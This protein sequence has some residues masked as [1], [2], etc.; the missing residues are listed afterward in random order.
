MQKKK[1]IAGIIILFSF[2]F[3]A[4]NLFA[5]WTQQTSGTSQILYS[6]YFQDSNNG[7]AVGNNSTI[8]NTT[9][10][11]TTWGSQT[12]PVA[13][14]LLW[15][16]RFADTSNGWAVGADGTIINTT[17]GGTTWT[18]QTSGT[19][20]TLWA[21]SVVD[22]N[23]AWAVG[24][25]GTILTTSD[26]GTTWTSQTSGTSNDL[27]G[28]FF[29]NSTTGW[30]V[31]VTGTILYTS[32]GG[33]SWT[34]QT[35]NTTQTLLDVF[36]FDANTGWAVG[37]TY[38]NTVL[39]GT[40]D[41]GTTWT[42]QT[43]DDM[44]SG[45]NSV[46]FLSADVGW[47]VGDSGELFHTSDG[48]TTWI[49]QD[50]GSSWDLYGVN[51]EDKYTGWQVGEAGRIWKY[52]GGSIS[53]KVTAM[54][55]ATAIAS[56]AVQAYQSGTLKSQAATSAAGS[57]TL[58]GLSAGDYA[59]KAT[60]TAY[61]F[62]SVNDKTVTAGATLTNINFT[63]D[64]LNNPPT[65]TIDSISGNT[66]RPSG[67]ITINYT[68]TDADSDTL[69][70]SHWQFSRDNETWSDIVAA[71]IGN[72]TAKAP[73]S[74]T[75]TWDTQSGTNNLDGISD[76]SVYFRMRVTDGNSLS[77]VA[78]YGFN[79]SNNI[80]G[81]AWDGTN[82]YSDDDGGYIYKHNNDV[83][84]STSTAYN[85]TSITPEDLAW[86]GTQFW[87]N[88]ATWVGDD[89]ICKL[90]AGDPSTVAASYDNPNTRSSS[91]LWG[92]DYDGTY[93]WTVEYDWQGATIYKL[94]VGDTLSVAAS[95]TAPTIGMT[96][97]AWDGANL[98]TSDSMTQSYL[99]IH[100]MDSTLSKNTTYT[101][102]TNEVF[103]SLDFDST[104]LW[105][106]ESADKLMKVALPLSFAGTS[107]SFAINNT[108]TYSISGTVKDSDSNAMTGV[109][110]TLSGDATD[111][112]T[113]DTSGVYSLSGLDRGDYVVTPSS[114]GY[115]FSPNNRSYTSLGADQTSQDFTG[116][117]VTGSTY[118]IKGYIKDSSGTAASSV[119]VTLSGDSTG[120]YA[121]GSNGYYE[122]LNLA[123]GDYTVTPSKTGC[124]FSP[125]SKTYSSLNANQDNQ[126]FTI[127]VV[128]VTYDIKGYV[129]DS[130]GVGI[131]DVVV[132]LS[133]DSSDTY[134]TGTDGYYEFLAL[135]TGDY[136]VTPS[137]SNYSF[138]PSGR[139]YSSL[140]S[141]QEDQDFT[142]TVA[143]VVYYIKG[144]V[145]D[146]GGSPIN[147]VTLSLTG[148]T[149]GSYITTATGYYEFLNLVSGDYV[150]TPTKT[151]YTFT[152]TAYTYTSLGENKDN[153]NFTGAG[154]SGVTEDVVVGRNK[155]DLTKGEY[156]RIIYNLASEGTVTIK[157]YDLT[158][159]LVRKLVDN[160]TR[161][162]GDNEER[163]DGK[164]DDAEKV[165][166]GIYFM[167]INTDSWKET[168]M[169]GV[170]RTR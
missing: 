165:A 88:S 122:F 28:V 132:N 74:S 16:V 53:G 18:A 45:L 24:A 34:E 61:G 143:A 19:S 102:S 32:N 103:G 75:I 43:N 23:T 155:I 70:T 82:I 64:T 15:E 131:S 95:Y 5:S 101:L 26:G 156:A 77:R 67:T 149:T 118:Y 133:G 111:T 68:T 136:S 97:V 38:S 83:S 144:F 127:T 90:T 113:T 112:T 93:L 124:T 55:G 48:G 160:E 41:G 108:P 80:V 163:W 121:T 140:S 63:L 29:V 161:T 46:Y 57:Y 162:A 151:E 168:K 12:C 10:G 153:Q 69:T 37:G 60:K 1:I 128:T 120:S 117:A 129:R 119:T 96:G 147:G 139:S 105:V 167:L 3:C 9:N 73:G 47:V 169:I 107:A 116:T 125:T 84:L 110:L 27:A 141:D 54:D 78:I 154:E 20:N 58:V 91:M 134:T 7:W 106:I 56:A 166:T 114:S 51:F 98:W 126:D 159:N 13:N 130:S 135:E 87:T 170:S 150:V 146:S 137:K 22:S 104:H 6:V 42:S 11:G 94:T 145:L 89:Q 85:I 35:S 99:Y 142:G 40:T 62:H 50:N 115:T 25:S 158:G 76:D 72:N 39:L 109:T 36:F 152:P 2:I 66:T 33:T 79:N 81:I 86:D 148:D 164:N 157:I 71:Q 14:K 44:T 138:S 4:N 59:I 92:I 65:V 30:A 123:S 17:D 8:I 49:Q 31:G 100:N 21:L 52:S